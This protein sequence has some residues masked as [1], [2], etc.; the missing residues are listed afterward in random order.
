MNALVIFGM[1]A[2]PFIDFALYSA[3]SYMANPRSFTLDMQKRSLRDWHGNMVNYVLV[4]YFLCFR[5]T[6]DVPAL[7]D[8]WMIPSYFVIVDVAFYGLHF[9]CHRFFYY[10]I[11]QKHHLCQPIGSHCARHSHWIDATLENISFFTP[12]FFLSYN[13]YC[14]FLCLLLNGVWAS[15]IHTHPTCVERGTLMVTPYLHWIHHQFGGTSSCN[16]ALYFTLWDRL[17]GT[18]NEDGRVALVKSE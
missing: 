5:F 17:L 10:R 8:G 1:F 15:Y 7:S 9:A 12:F 14:A 16:Y 13:A 4:W 3:S 18:L 11:H 2:T 6:W